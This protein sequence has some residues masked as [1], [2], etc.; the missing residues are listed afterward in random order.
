VV[1]LGCGNGATAAALSRLG[2]RV[3]GIDASKSGI[4]AASRADPEVDFR[5][6]SVYDDLA[7]DLGTFEI[8]ISLDVIEHLY[9]PR[10]F[11]TRL[12][13]LLAP[14]G[15]GILSTPYHGYLKNLAI[16]LAGRHDKHVTSLWEGG[17][18]KFFSVA[19]LGRILVEAGF[20]EPDVLRVGRCPPLAKSMLAV[21]SRPASA[22]TR[23]GGLT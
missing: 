5:V 12:F 13:A 4:A 19:T 21:F 16:A 20:S 10:L 17:H 11:L 2:Y 18:V 7:R 23:P 3:T 8:A 22:P 9:S 1:D 6:G 15:T 14:G